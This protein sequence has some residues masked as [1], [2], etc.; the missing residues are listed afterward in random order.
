MTAQ[1]PYDSRAVANLLLDAADRR[2]LHLTQLSLYKLLYFS[3]GWYLADKASPL[4]IH[5][6]EAW[7][8]GPVVKVLRDE[9]AKFKDRP[10]TSRA[11]KLDIYTGHRI[12]VNP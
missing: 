11:Y 4:I 2:R 9:F 12:P 6:F 5:D 1:A 7:K 10:I 8:Y 3:H